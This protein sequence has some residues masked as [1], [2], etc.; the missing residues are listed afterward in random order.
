MDFNLEDRNRIAHNLGPIYTGGS[1][2]VPEYTSNIVEYVEFYKT[3]SKGDAQKSNKYDD[4]I[5]RF[6]IDHIK[7]VEKMDEETY[8]SQKRYGL[9]IFIIMILL[10]T[11]GICFSIVQLVNAIKLGQSSLPVTTVELQAGGLIL[12]TSM[13]GAF[14]LIVSLIFFFLFLKF[15]YNPE[16]VRKDP[17]RYLPD[18][19]KLIDKK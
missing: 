7:K 17:F 3:L 18:I 10:V 16:N 1:A 11:A 4:E 12:S 15:V 19:K 9:F 13:I 6:Y 14:V 8:R 2:V 5:L